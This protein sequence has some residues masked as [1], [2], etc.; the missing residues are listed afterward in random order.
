M[1]L[2]ATPAWNTPTVTTADCSG[3]TLRDTIDCSAMTMLEPAT[4]GSAL[5]CGIAACPP[6]PRTAMTTRSAEAS[7]APLRKASV[8]T[9]C[10]GALCSA[11]TASQGKRWNSPSSTMRLAPPPPSSAGWKIRFSVPLKRRVC[12]RWR[13]AASSVAVWPSW[14]QAC[15]LPWCRL[16]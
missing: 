3:S 14:P 12:A 7:A 8:P 1:T 5:K 2:L 13:A 15:I 9:G 16:A 6:L 4:I 10:P 11:N